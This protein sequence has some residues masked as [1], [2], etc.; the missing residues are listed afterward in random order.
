M[1]VQSTKNLY[2]TKWLELKQVTYLDKT[3]NK[4][5]WDY[6]SRNQNRQIVSVVCRSRRYNKFLFISQPRAS[7]N[8]IEISFPA[9]L[10]DK[11]ET[12]QQAALRELKEETGYDGQIVSISPLCTKSAGLSD[13]RTYI[14]ECIVDE[15]AVGNSEMEITEDIQYFWKTPNQF[16]NFVE[17]LDLRKFSISS[18]VFN[19]I[20]GHQYSKK[21]G[22]RG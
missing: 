15:K 22:N 21:R 19:F 13:E 6:V 7:I 16:Q 2:A 20:L 8:Q 5:E 4:Q 9:G 18:N 14:V 12:P 10:V 1:K 17:T 3:G 11:G